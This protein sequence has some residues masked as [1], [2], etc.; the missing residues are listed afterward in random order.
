MSET[1]GGGK[2][3][4]DAGAGAG[5]GA[6]GDGDA[7]AEAELEAEAVLET[8]AG[9]LPSV[10][11][12]A[13]VAFVVLVG[14]S[15]PPCAGASPAAT[16]DGAGTAGGGS[17]RPAE[18]IVTPSGADSRPVLTRDFHSSWKADAGKVGL[19]RARVLLKRDSSLS[20]RLDS[21]ARARSGLRPSPGSFCDKQNV[22]GG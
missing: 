12:V 18:A 2:S 21:C 10:A 4:A 15:T 7:V 6:V 17:S 3:E 14:L 11:F 5:A 13:V 20:K 16:E 9:L 22:G 19:E 1:M 8:G